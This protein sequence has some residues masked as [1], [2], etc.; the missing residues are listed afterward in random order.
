M[1]LASH[2][3][4]ESVVEYQLHFLHGM[5]SSNYAVGNP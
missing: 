5:P 4:V 2:G 1:D 3:S